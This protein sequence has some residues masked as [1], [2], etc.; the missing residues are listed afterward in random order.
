MAAGC[1]KRII[2]YG[3]E[4]KPI[5][6]YCPSVISLKKGVVRFLYKLVTVYC[7]V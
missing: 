5:S 3:K 4:G 2:A 1:D 7:Q 6:V